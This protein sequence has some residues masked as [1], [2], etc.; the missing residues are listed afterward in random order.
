LPCWAAWMEAQ[1][2]LGRRAPSGLARLPPFQGITIPRLHHLGARRVRREAQICF[3]VSVRWS[4]AL[5]MRV[6]AEGPAAVSRLSWSAA[7]SPATQ[8]A[9]R[10]LLIRRVTTRPSSDQS[11]AMVPPSWAAILRCTN[12]LPKPSGFV[13]ATTGGPPP[14]GPNNHHFVLM[15]VAGH[16]QGTT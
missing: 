7:R 6:A 2:E 16:V 4:D 3:G 14:F 11:K 8:F 15:R 1:G 12:L 10:S 5:S 13:G 9:R